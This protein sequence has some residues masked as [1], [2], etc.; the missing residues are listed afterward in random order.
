MNS[1]TVHWNSRLAGKI[2]WPVVARTLAALACLLIVWPLHAA[3]PISIKGLGDGIRHW[4]N[5]SGTDGYPS[6]DASQVREIAENLLRYQRA[7]AAGRR[8]STHCG[9]STT[10]N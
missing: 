9:S 6:Y 2:A 10:R 8:I 4:K 7:T 5:G 1:T 3:E